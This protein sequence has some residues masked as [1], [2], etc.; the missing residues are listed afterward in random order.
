MS[1]WVSGVGDGQ[2]GGLEALQAR[3]EEA[4]T[5]VKANT[6]ATKNKN[7]LKVPDET[8]V[9]AT[10]A[11]KCRNL[12]LRKELRKKARKARREFDARVSALP[13]GNIVRRPHVK[14]L[15]VDGRA[16]EDR[17]EW[18][19]EVRVHCERC[20]DDKDDISEVQAERIREQRCRLDTLVAWQGR[21][22]QSPSLLPFEHEGK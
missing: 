21:K 8:R 20:Y 9:M 13:T 15:Q 10:A 1:E 6:R 22:V 19:E 17:E 11:A 7:K 3:L 18:M 12:F 4:A 5:N 16:S 2:E 14:K